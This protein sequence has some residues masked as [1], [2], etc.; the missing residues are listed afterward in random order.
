[1]SGVL[2]LG[3]RWYPK[4]VLTLNENLLKIETEDIIVTKRKLLSVSQ[5]IFDPIRFTCPA[6]LRPKLWLQELWSRNI[7]WDTALDD[8]DMAILFKEWTRKIPS[9]L[10]IELPRWTKIDGTNL[11]EVSLHVFVDASKYAYATA[12]FCRVQEVNKVSVYLM[13]AKSRI[14][15]IEKTSKTL[16]IPRLELLTAT[17]GSRLYSQVAENL[18]QRYE[19]YFWSDS[20][21]I[22][23]WIQRNEH[24][25][26]FVH[27]RVEEIRKLTSADS[28]HYIQVAETRLTCLHVG[29]LLLIY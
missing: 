5:K 9:L 20:T 10:Q 22:I 24:W 19:T 2:V 26:T 17:I 13:A 6:T 25:G 4:D 15:P 14:A 8:D 27:N 28:W 7:S 16:R 21:T 3:L 18:S 29:V 1:M 12:I 23:S 11:E